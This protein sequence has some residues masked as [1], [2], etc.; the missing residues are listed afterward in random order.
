[1]SDRRGFLAGL[2][3]FGVAP[4]PTWADVGNP[5]YVS[6][7]RKP[8][9]RFSLI[10]L[11]QGGQRRF[12]ID[13]PQRGH[14]AAAHPMRPEAVAFARRPGRYAIVFDCRTG[15]QIAQVD[16]PRGRHFYGHGAF[17]IDG[18]VLF[19]TENDYEAALGV[20]GM[21]DTASGY[22]RIGEVPSG[23]IGP[24]DIRLLPGQSR[25]VVAN[26]GIET[27]PELGRAKLNIPTMEP[28]LTVIDFHGTIVDTLALPREVHKNSIR[29][30]SVS[31]SGA[32]AFAMQW[33]G[34]ASAK[35]PLLGIWRPG[36]DAVLLDPGPEAIRR[37]NH[38]VGSVA[39]DATGGFV[40]ASSPRG[41]V[42]QVFDAQTAQLVSESAIAD[43][44]GV[45]A[46]RDGFIVTDG[47]GKVTRVVA[48][49]EQTSVQHDVQWDNHLVELPA[50]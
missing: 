48:L 44:C 46:S 49:S 23:G 36:S 24:H 42:Y 27:H 38:Y 39:F 11:S 4:A 5:R 13:L 16:A 29:H 1:M 12:E 50:I 2:L 6:A 35:Y 43:V 14:A 20:V 10:G 40:I 7:A 33:Q 28:N 8:D 31:R 30:L 32:I 25:L 18:S 45:A 19:T 9:G 17:S 22:T 34:D 15:R 21:W 37:M 3:A 41:G 26:G 47:Q